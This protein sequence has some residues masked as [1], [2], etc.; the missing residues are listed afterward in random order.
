MAGESCEPYVGADLP[1]CPLPFG[2]TGRFASTKTSELV[3]A[4]FSPTVG[5]SR[6]KQVVS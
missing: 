5:R 2:Q 4:I 6:L 3:D 1:D